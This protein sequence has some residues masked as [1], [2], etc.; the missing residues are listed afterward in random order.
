MLV[1]IFKTI[2]ITSLTGTSLAIILTM[3]K[4]LT[5]KF[6]SSNWHYYMWLA[7]L[8]IMLIPVSIRLPEK[9]HPDLESFSVETQTQTAVG[10]PITPIEQ[11][12]VLADSADAEEI[13]ETPRV[14][15]IDLMR[16]AA[17]LWLT[18]AM[19]LFLARLAGYAAFLR[20]LRRSSVS[21]YCQELAEFTDRKIET[22]VSDTISSP[23]M[24]GIFKPMLVLPKAEFTPEQ[25]HNILA[26]E[27][28]HFKRKDIWYKW[29]AL[30]VKCIHWFNPAVYFICVQINKECEIS[31]DLAV[32]RNMTK[33]QKAG[34]IDTI[35]RLLSAGSS[36]SASLTTGMALSKRTLK[37]RFLMIKNKKNI[38]R[39]AVILSV[40]LAAMALAVT[41]FAGGI[42]NG[43][44]NK[45]LSAATDIR[46]NSGFNALVMGVDEQGRA[47][48]IMVLSIDGNVINGISIP[49]NVEYNGKN[50]SNLSP[51]E[52][53][54]EKTVEAVR[55]MLSIPINYYARVETDAI[56]DIVNAVGGVEF[57]V[58]MDME[59]DDPYKNLHI[60]LKQGRQLLDGEKAAQLLRFRHS[61][62][63][64]YGIFTGYENG[65]ITRIEVGQS[66]MKALAEKIINTGGF[67]NA[68]KLYRTANVI[69][70]YSLNDLIGDIDMFKDI[71]ADKISFSTLPGTEEEQDNGVFYKIDLS[72]AEALLDIFRNKD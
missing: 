24:T 50:I 65:D 2:L 59:Y 64:E 38:G 23:F 47:D 46:A 41:A 16:L 33:D 20:R 63:N 8:V 5:K 55:E 45:N 29:F 28:T 71:T 58:P 4:P 12:P 60:D 31:C 22:L 54:C 18:I 49:R 62:M 26:H 52:N 10:T 30:A 14:I 48:S 44:L 25:L 70:D 37:T 69:T 9:P 40:I 43:R 7:V 53:G 34:Y 57:N 61:N 72:E 32:V 66:F 21:I 51:E 35:L 36:K 15:P 1:N 67:N 3:V 13:P 56:E 39:R 6:F 11:A 42:V 68:A 27:I 17:V 19:I